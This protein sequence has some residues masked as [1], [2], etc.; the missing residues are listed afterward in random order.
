MNTNIIAAF[1]DVGINAIGS[2]KE[3]QN[4]DFSYTL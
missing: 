4:M 3:M 1:G 2:L